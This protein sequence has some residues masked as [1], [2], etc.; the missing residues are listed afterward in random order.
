MSQAARRPKGAAPIRID[1][2]E[3]SGINATTG[4]LRLAD[5]PLETIAE[6]LVEKLDS[7]IDEMRLHQTWDGKM[8]QYRGKD[9]ASYWPS[10]L[11][12]A[13]SKDVYTFEMPRIRWGSERRLQENSLFDRPC[14]DCYALIGEFHADECD[15]E[16]CPLCHDQ[17]LSCECRRKYSRY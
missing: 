15:R 8:I 3:I 4:Y 6:L 2:T 7:N 5:Y 1:D 9:A 16:E 11:R 12:M 13:Q 17:A 10:V 14:S